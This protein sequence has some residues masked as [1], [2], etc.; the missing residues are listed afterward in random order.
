MVLASAITTTAFVL[1]FVGL[2]LAVLAFAFSGGGRG[3]ATKRSSPS[4]RRA[5]LA[6]VAVLM[7]AFGIGIPAVGIAVNSGSQSKAAP[8]G[9]NLTASQQDGRKLFARR[10]STCHTLAASNSVGRV[11]PNLDQ[12]RPPKALTLNAIAMG[13]ARG[14]GQMPAGILDGQDA[15]D[16]ASFIAVAAGR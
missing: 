2:G 14:A 6:A 15:E 7:L 4:S 12:L 5:G 13:R 3:S 1:L 11:G 8:G 10:C 16:V 9:L